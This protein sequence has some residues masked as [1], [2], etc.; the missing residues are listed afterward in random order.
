MP[1]LSERHDSPLGIFS[2]P[3]VRDLGGASETFEKILR[4]S[5]ENDDPRAGMNLRE[6]KPTLHAKVNRAVNEHDLAVHSV[7]PRRATADIDE[8]FIA[9]T[10]TS[11]SSAALLSAG[12]ETIEPHIIVTGKHSGER[13]PPL[14]DVTL[15]LPDTLGMS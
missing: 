9:K 5:G 12:G 6:D 11:D 4:A 7:T 8:G 1:M 3:F 10:L 15:A 2:G 13:Q 14:H